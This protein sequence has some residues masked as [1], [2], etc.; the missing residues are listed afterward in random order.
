MKKIIVTLLSVVLVASIFTGC[1][2]KKKSKTDNS[3]KTVEEN[4]ELV[5]GLDASFPPMGFTDKDQNTVGFDIDL[6]KEVTKRMGIKLKLQ[7][8]NWDSKDQEL[9]NRNI[10]CIWNGLTY[11]EDRAKDMLCSTPYMENHQVLVLPANSKIKS[12]ADIKK[13]TV[14]V[15]KGSTANDAVEK[16][17]ELKDAKILTMGNN[18][19]ILNDLGL[20]CDAAVMDEVVAK[21]YTNKD[22]GKYKILAADLAAEDYVIG[23]RKG[24]KKLCAAVEEQLKAMAKDG[25]LAKISKKWFNE[26][27]TTIK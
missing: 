23:F 14:E 9:N 21:Y 16:S 26:D 4:G 7:P 1:G 8:I 27:I 17:K 19:E 20:G 18:V 3:L 13:K 6:A 22:K 24:E 11:N 15:Q 10:D 5:L 25:T 12:L 2:A